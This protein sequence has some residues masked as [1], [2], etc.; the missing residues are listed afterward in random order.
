MIDASDPK[1]VRRVVNAKEAMGVDGLTSW[2]IVTRGEVVVGGSLVSDVDR[3]RAAADPPTYY[4][5]YFF[6]DTTRPNTQYSNDKH[7]VNSTWS[8]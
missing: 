5:L 1:A 2:V 7:E 4:I 3:A 6:L 8:Y